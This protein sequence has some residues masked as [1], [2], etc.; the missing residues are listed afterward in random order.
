MFRCAAIVNY[1]A[2]ESGLVKIQRGLTLT[3]AERTACAE[4]RVPDAEDG[5]ED[6]GDEPSTSFVAQAYKRRK[7]TKRSAYVDVGYVLPTSNECERLFS[8]A[9]LIFSDLRKSMDRVTLETLVVLHCNRSLW[10]VYTVDEVL[11][12]LKV[13][14]TWKS[15]EVLAALEVLGARGTQEVLAALAFLAA[16]EVLVAWKTQEPLGVLAALESG[17]VRPRAAVAA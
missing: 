1:P 8:R 5:A 12:A 11:V 2:L 6:Q 3:A 9:K 15:L 7:T 14:A 17:D 10:N 4:F 13:L 16:L